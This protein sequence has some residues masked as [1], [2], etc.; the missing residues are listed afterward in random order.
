MFWLIAGLM[1][2]LAL[3]F[4]LPP[5]W[6]AHRG[7]AADA[8]D[9]RRLQAL[10]HAH[11]AGVL[12]DA[13]YAE[14]RAAFAAETPSPDG[15]RP[16][17]AA[18]ALALVIPFG[19]WMMYGQL[20]EPAGLD[21]EARRAGTG[22][23]NP[24]EA[25]GM[26]SMDMEQAIA[27]LAQRLRNEPDNI[28]GWLLLGRAYKSME[29]FEPAREALAQAYRLAPDDTDV[30]IEFAEAIALS[31]PERMFGGQSLELLQQAMTREPDHQRGI[32]LLGVA[33]MQD[34]RY[35][36]AIAHWQRLQ[37]MLG[38]DADAIESLQHQIDAARAR[39]GDAP[40]AQQAPQPVLQPGP[41]AIAPALPAGEPADS[42][43]ASDGSAAAREPRLTVQV[44][45]TPALRAQLR[46]SDVLF[47]YAR[48]PEG[49]PV[50]IA[51]RR[52]A[53]ASLPT[54]VVLDD[55]TSMM[56]QL[57]LS[58]LPEVVV[59][60]RISRA[61]LATPERGDFETYTDPV[62]VSRQQ[63]LLLTIDRI[64]E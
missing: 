20:G 39:G 10:E 46:S 57:K 12:S 1:S 44:D 21:P 11:A 36:Q 31:S 28:D 62:A 47:V 8:T 63:P 64:I 53:A 9:R 7:D 14:K 5:L 51:I 45:I 43:P 37:A 35:T 2:L 25:G 61:G 59:G 55:S 30:M 52:L 56:P 19:A 3:A 40:A 50:P 26:G 49:S 34:G 48:A 24:H 27:G 29:R 60:A 23:V 41:V 6:R 17:I 16:W 33:A 13:E 18:A 58:T 32:W 4:V 42:S 38:D 15:P 54:T 22:I